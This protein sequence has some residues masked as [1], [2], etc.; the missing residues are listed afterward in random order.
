MLRPH[1]IKA[2]KIT[3][4]AGGAEIYPQGGGATRH[5][6][7]PEVLYTHRTAVPA[8]RHAVPA[9]RHAVLAHRTAV[10]AQRT[11]PGSVLEALESILA[12]MNL[13]WQPR[14]LS[15]RTV[16]QPTELFNP[17]TCCPGPQTCCS[18]PQD[19]CSGP[20][21]CVTLTLT[22]PHS[23]SPCCSSLPNALNQSTDPSIDWRVRSSASRWIQLL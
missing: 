2:D 3:N 21:D 16:L 6:K 14:G 13:F 10:P 8:H 9:H 12:A 22:H 4:P 5:I 18:R 23:P 17:Q 19:C 7:Q 1:H 11:A 15:V 20:Q